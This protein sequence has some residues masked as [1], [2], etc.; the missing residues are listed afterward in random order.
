ML[1][2]IT[3]PGTPDHESHD[4]FLL[5]RPL[6]RPTLQRGPVTAARSSAP[7]SPAFA[8]ARGRG[9]SRVAYSTFTLT[10]MP[11][12]DRLAVLV[13][14]PR[15]HRH[16][17]YGVLAP[18]SPL[19]EAVTA[20][21]QPTEMAATPTRAEPIP[22]EAARQ[23]RHIARQR[24]TPGRC[25]WRASTRCCRCSARVRWR[26]APHRLDH[27]SGGDPGDFRSLERADDTAASDAGV[28]ATA[29]G[30]AGQRPGRE[31]AILPDAGPV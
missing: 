4:R 8:P 29:V 15:R 20:L 1:M 25:C 7:R 9:G 23:S 26:D 27:R 14:P 21:A 24:A 13:P 10:P 5:P 12:L 6:P 19:R 31:G 17:T 3:F 28:R 30:D 16:R 18:N 22:P 2:V 11:L